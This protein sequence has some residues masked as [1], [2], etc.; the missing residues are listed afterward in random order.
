MKKTLF[1]SLLAVV[2]I[3]F[4]CQRVD[5]T[6][7]LTKTGKYPNVKATISQD[8]RISLNGTALQWKAGDQISI[9]KDGKTAIYQALSAGVTSEFEY[10]SGEW[11]EGTGSMVAYYPASLAAE[12]FAAVY[13]TEE[14][15]LTSLPLRG[16]IATV[17]Q[18]FTFR[19]FGGL[20]KFNVKTDDASSLKLAQIAITANENI[21]G[22]FTDNTASAE[23][24]TA[25]IDG[26]G[27]SIVLNLSQPIS[28]TSDAKSVYVA[29]PAL[30]YTSGLKVSFRCDNCVRNVVT[31]SDI[32][33]ERAHIQPVDVSLSATTANDAIV[34]VTVNNGVSYMAFDNLAE[35]AQAISGAKEDCRIEVL[36][37]FTI[38]ERVKI[39]GKAFTFDGCGHTVT[40]T[41]SYPEITTNYQ[42][43]IVVDTLSDIHFINTAFVG[44]GS[45]ETTTDRP[46]AV[47][48]ATA[49]FG[50][51]VTISGFKNSRPYGGAI[52]GNYIAQIELTDN[53]AISDCH[54]APASSNYGG[55]AVCCDGAIIMKDDASIKNCSSTFWGGAILS[56]NSTK[57]GSK[58]GLSISGNAE[59]SNCSCGKT[60]GAFYSNT[61]TTVS[62]NVLLSS[63]TSVTSGGAMEIRGTVNIGG[64]TVIEHCTAEVNAGA[65]LVNAA[66]CNLTLEGNLRITDCR[67]LTGIGGAVRSS[68][69]E[70]KVNVKDDVCIDHCS[71]AITGGA[72]DCSG[73]FTM[74][75]NSKIDSC[76][77]QFG[78]GIKIWRTATLDG[79]ASIV[80][81]YAERGGAIID[82]TTSTKTG[83]G[84]VVIKGNFKI[85]NCTAIRGGGI[86]VVDN[87]V[88]LCDISENAS[89][90]G[91]TATASG[92]AYGGGIFT[93]GKV[94]IGGNATMTDNSVKSTGSYSCYGSA[95]CAGKGAVTINGGSI[96]SNSSSNMVGVS[97][98][99]GSVT[100]TAG[101]HGNF[102]TGSSFTKV[103][104][105]CGPITVSGGYH[106]KAFKSTVTI[107]D[108]YAWGD[109]PNTTSEEQAAYAAGFVYAVRPL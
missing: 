61:T 17:E 58:S 77:A 14:G 45:S 104:D 83:Y 109:N 6:I 29:V 81:C 51:D 82:T 100:L 13:S 74:T 60:G 88:A 50:K 16:E 47:V 56:N 31:A 55:G 68:Y 98:A 3:A 12:G 37:D 39:K 57:T 106:N 25:T 4:S 48:H 101:C 26:T 79:D 73:Y 9:A 71:C 64:N 38:S 27:K 44:P 8:T 30:T 95:I 22:A 11:G 75:G 54:N 43:G 89:I 85:E 18:N 103:S 5:E 21:A 87:A 90:T 49:R 78:G 67:A 108:G 59:I 32:V 99:A 65:I 15:E 35:A 19:A 41:G 34:K 53:V 20:F 63:C 40:L 97:N 102:G 80:S 2:A 76:S 28:L 24:A 84:K 7:E 91:C 36:K 10:V 69:L 96:T 62:D 105:S 72:I 92:S 70:A 46:F 86:Y 23:T 52:W 94:T 33:I 1:L 107:A 66:T 42:G 93:E